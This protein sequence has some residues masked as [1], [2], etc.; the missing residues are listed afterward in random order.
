MLDLKYFFFDC[1]IYLVHRELFYQNVS[2]FGN[3]SRLDIGVRDVCCLLDTPPWDLGV[4]ATAKGLIA[5]PLQI[6][7]SD[8]T[9][10]DCTMSGGTP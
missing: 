2:R 4:V 3:Q 5:G 6:Y 8:G 1:F 9:I 7:Q 10:I